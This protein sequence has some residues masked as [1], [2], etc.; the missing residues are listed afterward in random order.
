MMTEEGLRMISLVVVLFLHWVESID[1]IRE[2]DK[3]VSLA[4]LFVAQ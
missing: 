3:E 1:T 4:L 2:L